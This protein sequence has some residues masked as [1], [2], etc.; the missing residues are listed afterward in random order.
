MAL[1]TADR[2]GLL[3]NG[4]LG[5]LLCLALAGSPTPAQ[6]SGERWMPGEPLGLDDVGS[7]ELLWKSKDGWI[8][9][10]MIRTD[11]ELTV[12]GIL[13][14]G[15]VRQIFRNGTDETIEVLYAFPLPARAAVQRMEMV[16]GERTIRSVI[17]EREAARRTY[18]QA[19]QSG[20]KAALL[21][22][23][24]ANL[25][26]I[27]AANINP[28]E[29]VTVVLEYLEE[30]PFEDGAFQLRFPLCFTPRFVPPDVNESLENESVGPRRERILAPAR[31][32]L[33][34]ARVR[35]ELRPGMALDSVESPSHPIDVRESA[36]GYRLSTTE[37]AIADR[38]FRLRW[39]P[40]LEDRP[41]A[42]VFVEERD[43]A[44]YALVMI[45]P[46]LPT[47]DTG[48][49]LPTET[50][51]VVDVSGSMAGPSIE[52]ARQALLAALGRLRPDDTFSLLKFN[53]R[54]EVFRE[55]FE[56]AED[57][58][59]EAAREWVRSLRADG[60]TM[61]Y[62]ALMR[63]LDLLGAS[64]TNRAQRMIFLTDGA[65]SNEAEVLRGITGQIGKARLHTIGIGNAPNEYLMRK[66]AW[67]GRGLCEFVSSDGETG[68]RI[69]AFFSRLDRPVM[70]DL[71]LRW[72]GISPGQVY[73]ARLSDLHAGQPLVLYARLD[74]PLRDGSVTL[75]GSSRSGWL[76]IGVPLQDAAPGPGV[77]A[78]WARAKVGSLMDSLHEG[79]PEEAVRT[80]VIDVGLDFGLVTAYTSLVAVEQVP[81][82]LDASHTE[83]RAA[84]MPLGGT[85][86]P[87]RLRL[88][89]ILAALGLGLLGLWGRPGR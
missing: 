70:V 64:R 88:G 25:F 9:L 44:S 30:V 53:D 68:N 69:D 72:D 47:S 27:S 13:L 7:G 45:A 4:S 24:Q 21:D 89:L 35:V 32:V 67:F 3:R 51:F 17:R 54:N 49:G 12:S 85:D 57:G 34:P 28:G 74:T 10:P 16:I 81:T 77:A 82:A 61:I 71:D 59:L 55:E 83:R 14:H 39:A 8:P 29:T 37:T 19:K 18:E 23:H 22:Q 6:E 31:A 60:G 86:G 80:A 1:G 26:K 63:G 36:G 2:Y 73:P 5:I 48:L 38:D 42:A 43:D 76:E 84:A 79:A 41:H 58:A 87:L 15:K 56:F 66:M 65:V 33:P 11:V 20:R 40:R 50:L 75:S 78:R 46:P 62:P 52:Q